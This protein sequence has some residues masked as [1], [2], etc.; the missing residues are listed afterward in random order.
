MNIQKV[1][2]EIVA[3]GQIVRVPLIIMDGA[4]G[5]TAI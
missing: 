3:D 5:E 2:D 1:D 4:I